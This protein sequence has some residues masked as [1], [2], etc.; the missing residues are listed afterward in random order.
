MSEWLAHAFCICEPKTSQPEV[1]QALDTDTAAWGRLQGHRAV[2]Q[3]HLPSIA[4]GFPGSSTDCSHTRMS[5]C[6]WAD[7]RLGSFFSRAARRPGSRSLQIPR[8]QIPRLRSLPGPD[9]GWEYALPASVSASGPSDREQQAEGLPAHRCHLLQPALQALCSR[10]ILAVASHVENCSI[11]WIS[12][13]LLPAQ[14][15][16]RRPG[17]SG[18]R[19]LCEPSPPDVPPGPVPSYLKRVQQPLQPAGLLLSHAACRDPPAQ[20]AAAQLASRPSLSCTCCGGLQSHRTLSRWAQAP[21]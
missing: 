21:P 5:V 12:L 3:R 11:A 19:Y 7:T 9:P 4:W 20:A 8:D 18:Q 17:S 2:A 10:A 16:G 6:A 14:W 13:K 15:L 1:E